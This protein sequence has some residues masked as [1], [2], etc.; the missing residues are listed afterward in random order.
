MMEAEMPE[1]ERWNE[2]HFAIINWATGHG[3]QVPGRSKW[4]PDQANGPLQRAISDD[5]S[6]KKEADWDCTSL[7]WFV[8]WQ[9]EM[10]FERHESTCLPGIGR[11]LQHNVL[12]L[13]VQLPVH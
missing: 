3:R 6:Q 10:I 7:S 13:G 11:G 5:S 12:L 2:Q 1:S 8:T 9:I 4:W